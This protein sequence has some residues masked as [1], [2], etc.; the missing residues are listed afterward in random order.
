MHPKGAPMANNARALS[1]A[2]ESTRPLGASN[3]AGKAQK[4]GSGAARGLVESVA[5]LLRSQFRAGLFPRI[6]TLPRS[7]L[8]SIEIAAMEPGGVCN[9]P[10]PEVFE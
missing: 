8:W 9:L 2:P 4:A 1:E 3:E 5:G 7:E 6:E 10:D